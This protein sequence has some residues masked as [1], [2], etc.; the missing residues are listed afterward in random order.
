MAR[1]RVLIT[2]LDWRKLGKVDRDK[3]KDAI[4]KYF[5]VGTKDEKK[6]LKRAALLTAC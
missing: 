1:E 2:L 6:R 3:V 5:T 4:M